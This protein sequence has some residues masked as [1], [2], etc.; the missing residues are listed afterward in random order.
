MPRPGAEPGTYA[1]ILVAEEQQ[2]AE[3]G[4]LGALDVQPGFYV[5]VGSARGPGGLK[6]R[7]ARH[8]RSEKKVR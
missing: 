6:A 4:K 7:I 3:I 8:T 5:Y 1:L 2:S